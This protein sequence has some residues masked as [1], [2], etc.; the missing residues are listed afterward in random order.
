MGWKNVQTGPEVAEH[1]RR[2][3]FRKDI[4]KLQL[5][6]NMQDFGFTERHAITNKVEINLYMLGPLVLHR[7]GGHVHGTDVITI[8]HGCSCG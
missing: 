1:R 3:P 6:W 7:V 5:R 4:N 8:N 2:Q